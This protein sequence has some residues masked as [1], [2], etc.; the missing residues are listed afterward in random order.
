MIIELRFNY[1]D[2]PFVRVETAKKQA[3]IKVISLLLSRILTLEKQCSQL[4]FLALSLL[5]VCLQLMD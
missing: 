2:V 1:H 5:G 3:M 4:M